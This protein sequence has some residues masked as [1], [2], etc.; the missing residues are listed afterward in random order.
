MW[1]WIRGEFYTLLMVLERYPKVWIL[2]CIFF[3]FCIAVMGWLNSQL[4]HYFE[5][6]SV[7]QMTPFMDQFILSFY[8]KIREKMVS[9]YLILGTLVL[10][11]IGYLKYRKKRLISRLEQPG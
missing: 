11:T 6:R 10:F 9:R 8:N 2:P 3:L 5:T 1:N 4:S 7:T